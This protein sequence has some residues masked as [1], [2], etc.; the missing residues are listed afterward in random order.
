V[1]ILMFWLYLA[2]L[3]VLVGGELN[4]Q[5][6]RAKPQQRRAIPDTDLAAAVGRVELEPTTGGL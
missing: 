1:I 4:A 5:T 6:Q 2:G 3:A